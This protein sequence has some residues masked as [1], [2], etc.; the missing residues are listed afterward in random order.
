MGRDIISLPEIK[1]FC[2]RHGIVEMQIFGS[3]LREDFNENSDIDFLVSFKENSEHTLFDLAKMKIELESVVGR[4][5]DIV[6]KKTLL[7]SEN[8][9]RRNAILNNTAM[10]YAA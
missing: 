1:D 6:N 8:Y 4:Q 10:V 5:V 7:K 3:V 9:I 2:F